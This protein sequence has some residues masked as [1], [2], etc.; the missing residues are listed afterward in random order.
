MRTLS[1]CEKGLLVTYILIKRFSVKRI[2][3]K[4]SSLSSKAKSGIFRFL[5]QVK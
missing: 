1:Q 4:D 2:L 5:G 3:E